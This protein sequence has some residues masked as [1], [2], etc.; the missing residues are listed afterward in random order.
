MPGTT[1]EAWLRVVV[2]KNLRLILCVCFGKISKIKV[3]NLWCFSQLFIKMCANDIRGF[4]VWSNTCCRQPRENSPGVT[5]KLEHSWQL[6]AQT[7]SILLREDVGF[8]WSFVQHV[9][10]SLARITYGCD[11]KPVGTWFCCGIDCRCVKWL[12]RVI[13]MMV[14][15]DFFVD[16]PLDFCRHSLTPMSFSHS[17]AVHQ[18]FTPGRYTWWKWASTMLPLEPFRFSGATLFSI[19]LVGNQ[20]HRTQVDLYWK[21]KY[22]GNQKNSELAI[23]RLFVDFPS[24]MCPQSQTVLQP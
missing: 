12:S 23:S 8:Q 4:H 10:K 6:T 17:T 7:Q 20:N 18:D 3:D 13:N 2:F 14:F 15:A 11:T 22:M 24:L 16:S 19:L 5:S 21:G 9:D 1:A